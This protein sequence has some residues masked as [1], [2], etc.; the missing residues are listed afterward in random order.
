[1]SINIG[2]FNMYKFS[3]NTSKELICFYPIRVKVVRGEGSNGF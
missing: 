2:S 1:M 3:K